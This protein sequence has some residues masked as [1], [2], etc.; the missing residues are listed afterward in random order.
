M[1]GL[2]KKI[3]ILSVVFI[4]AIIVY[5]IWN[6]G[7]EEKN[8][9]MIYTS[10]EEASLPVVYEDIL[11]RKM[12]FLHGYTQ[13]MKQSVSREALALLPED[14]SMKIG[15]SGY[16]GKINGMEY[17]IRSLDLE[18]L[19]ERTQVD[20]WEDEG[21]EIKASLPIQN[22]LAK[23]KEYLLILTLDTPDKGKLFYYT[24]I[25]WTDSGNGKEMVDFA[26]DFATKTF[27]YEK[28]R[29][30][31]TYLETNA[32]E[33][34][35]SFASVNI[36]SSFSVLT[37]G[38]LS[39]EPAGE[40]RVTLK[41][42]NGVMGTVCLE[43]EIFRNLEDGTRELYEVEDSFTMRW[44]SSR[45]YL[46]NFERRTNQIFSGQRELFSGQRIMLGIV[47]NSRLSTAK[48]PSAGILAYVANRDLWVYNQ[49]Q[50]QGVKVFSLRSGEE[51]RGRD[52]ER[53][54]DI[55]ILSVYDNGDV[56][57]L[58]YG[59]MN[60]GIH[61]GSV[62]I[63]VYRY[64]G[65][66]NS[67]EERFFTPV[68]MSFEILKE[69]VDRLAHLGANG[70]LY[71]MADRTVYGIDLNSNEYMVLVESLQEG[72]YAVSATE[73]HFV[74]QEVGLSGAGT[75][76]LM[77]LETGMSREIAG[78]EEE[79]C[80]PL[81]FVGE[82]F[83]Y[84][85]ARRADTWVL[86][87]RMEEEPMY[88]IDIMDKSGKIINQ[89]EQENVYIVQVSVEGS[90]IHLTHA[91]KTG[92]QSFVFSKQ[93][94]I[95]CNQ[96]LSQAG[97]AGLETY[98]EKVRKKVYVI[99]LDKSVSNREVKLG[100]PKKVIHEAAKYVELK[101]GTKAGES[102]FYA[103][104]AGRY[105]GSS[106]DFTKALSLAYEKMG[107][108]TDQNGQTLWNRVNRPTV[109]NLKEPLKAGASF[110]NRLEGFDGS[111]SFGEEVFLLDARGC[112]LNQVL[113][114]V[115][116]GCPVAAYTGSGNYLLI[117]GYDRHYVTLYNP[118]S[119]ENQKMVLNEAA[120]YFAERGNDFVCGVFLK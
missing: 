114:F 29:E 39:V 87:G 40:M 30:L 75:I 98:E 89:Y 119:D 92:E 25:L 37:W 71:L 27:D 108:V 1:N 90:R 47:D 11:G 36:R 103:Y 43:Y 96:E 100:I 54:Y 15:I 106:R 73:H 88:R 20:T 14:R 107:V 116:Q 2:M 28:A 56:D 31:T 6:R 7:N 19:V 94:T 5:F 53:D 4:A 45:I 81:G 46:M 115:G 32:S 66:D 12:N 69:D 59:Y 68:T 102:R 33:D 86:N 70:M 117:S 82:D 60:R 85:T 104:G 99:R 95:V 63:A 24:R 101:S 17:E 50:A 97:Q 49:N 80:Q 9:V 74:W 61:E 41:D 35:S 76:H 38:S 93:D 3:R 77:N 34:N 62:G 18:Q 10:I 21:G 26:V 120:A 57:F 65:A 112:T 8:G 111:N 23:G 55:K 118:V 48:S 78:S 64:G 44:D 52:G 13:D 113:Y 83:V 91:V 105:L 109:R 16:S 72:A 84:G 110:L 79:I 22:L 58:V 51:V 67:I 42:L